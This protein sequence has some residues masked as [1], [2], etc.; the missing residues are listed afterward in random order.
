MILIYM[1]FFSW[2]RQ[3]SIQPDV[4]MLIL[5]CNGCVYMQIK[6]DCIYTKQENQNV[7]KCSDLSS[8]HQSIRIHD[9]VFSSFTPNSITVAQNLLFPQY[10]AV[11]L[12]RKMKKYLSLNLSCS[13]ES[14]G[15]K[16]K[17]FDSHR[18]SGSI[19]DIYGCHSLWGGQG[20]CYWHL[21]GRG[22]EQCQISHR[23]QNNLPNKE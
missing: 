13:H 20:G 14:Q 1:N 21:L 17:G 8:S 23:A 2:L 3:E 16:G 7:E 11:Y 5:I 19:G 4:Y 6:L 22:Q 12:F 15:G 9:G 18:S 10:D